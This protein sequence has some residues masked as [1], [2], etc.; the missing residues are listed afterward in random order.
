MQSFAY[1]CSFE[2]G[3]RQ[4]VVEVTLCASLFIPLDC[5]QIFSLIFPEL[6]KEALLLKEGHKLTLK[7]GLQAW[8]GV[9]VSAQQVFVRL[10]LASL[11]AEMFQVAERQP[12]GHY[13]ATIDWRPALARG[14]YTL[15]S[16]VI[17][18]QRSRCTGSCFA[19]RR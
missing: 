19:K 5:C 15:V 4:G 9:L 14:W 18:L 8:G 10:E 17:G 12:T 11:E 6:T 3:F 2:D 13:V 1:F 16:C 7:F